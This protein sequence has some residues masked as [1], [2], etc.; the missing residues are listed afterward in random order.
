MKDLPEDWFSQI[1]QEYPKRAKGC[2]YGWPDAFRQAQTRMKEGHSF[3]DL[4]DGTKN[5]CAGSKACGNYGTEYIKQASTFYGPGLH[6]MDEYETE[7]VEEER[8]YRKPEV[9]TDEAKAED[10]KK[11]V[12][13][14]AQYALKVVK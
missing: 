5:Y 12:E 9:Y 4:L 14:M 6:F 2:G 8:E 3:A 1:K 13:E 7:D 10:A 11:A